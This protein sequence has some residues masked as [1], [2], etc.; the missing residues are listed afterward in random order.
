LP[1]DR[2]AYFPA[3]RLEA[4]NGLIFCLVSV[5]GTEAE[6][7]VARLQIPFRHFAEGSGQVLQYQPALY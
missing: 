3:E 5:D 6:T 2:R 1:I 7:W 4:F